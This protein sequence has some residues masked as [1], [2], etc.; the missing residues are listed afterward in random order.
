MYMYKFMF[1]NDYI[2][3]YLPGILFIKEENNKSGEWVGFAV[4]LL[5]EKIFMVSHVSC[6]TAGRG[7]GEPA[8]CCLIKQV[9]Q[10]EPICVHTQTKEIL[11]RD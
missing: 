4:K 8:T 5:L 9:F 10:S 1:K 2:H 3:M 6:S 11:D 7:W